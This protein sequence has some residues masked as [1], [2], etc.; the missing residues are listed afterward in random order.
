MVTRVAKA[1]TFQLWWV[2]IKFYFLAVGVIAVI[3]SALGFAA[4]AIHTKRYFDQA[5]ISS[6]HA[7]YHPT[8]GSIEWRECK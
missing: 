1:D 4:G 3:C 5:A 7:Q 6:G 2:D 8:K